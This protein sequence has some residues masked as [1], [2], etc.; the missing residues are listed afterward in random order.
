LDVDII[1]LQVYQQV[2]LATNI[3]GLSSAQYFP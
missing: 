2:C 3:L 1:D